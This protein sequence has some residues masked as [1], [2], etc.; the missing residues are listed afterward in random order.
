VTTPYPFLNR[1][2]QEFRIF[3][4]KCLCLTILIFCSFI[5]KPIIEFLIKFISI[6]DIRKSSSFSFELESEPS[7]RYR[8]GG[9]RRTRRR[10]KSKNSFTNRRRIFIRIFRKTFLSTKTKEKEESSPSAKRNISTYFVK[11]LNNRNICFIT[12]T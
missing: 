2:I 12:T 4:K 7:R 11:I 3:M 1:F 10:T 9:K 8:T 6:D 5:S